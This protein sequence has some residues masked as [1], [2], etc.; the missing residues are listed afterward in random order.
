MEQEIELSK[1]AG[2]RHADD[3]PR[4]VSGSLRF[5]ILGPLRIWRDD[6]ELSAG[7]R[8]QGYLLALLLARAE[9]PI[10]VSNLIELLWGEDAPTSATNVIHKYV[11]TLRRLM[12]PSLPPRAIGS[13][14]RRHGGGYLFAPG[15]GTLDLV[16]FRELTSAARASLA[17]RDRG[18]A[19]DSYVEALELWRGPAGLLG[20]LAGAAASASV[21]G[22]HTGKF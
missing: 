16:S 10:S 12:E 11:G 13:Y 2:A 17:Q 21:A 4:P 9:R 7:P 5:Q 1:S 22:A 14:L 3:A 20:P 15:P 8:Q 19:L 6:I 18:K